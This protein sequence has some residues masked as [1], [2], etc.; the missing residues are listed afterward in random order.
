MFSPLQ[1][2]L[3][4]VKKDKKYSI[5]TPACLCLVFLLRHQGNVVTREQLITFA[6]GEG[7]ITY[8]TNNT[9][10]QTISH[11]RKV[12]DAVDCGNMVTTIPRIGLTIGQEHSIELQHADTSAGVA[13]RP[14]SDPPPRRRRVIKPIYLIILCVVLFTLPLSIGGI[15]A[16]R[17]DIFAHWQ[18]LP[19][20]GCEVRYRGSDNADNILRE[21]RNNNVSCDNNN[22]IFVTLNARIMRTSFLICQRYTPQRQLCHVLLVNRSNAK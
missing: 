5:Q 2:V 8:V 9:F 18:L 11:L 6:W 3:Y 7:A 21:M 16:S 12:L 20:Q 13:P 22:A 14:Q 15:M 1:R 10:Y 19:D 4:V 17:H